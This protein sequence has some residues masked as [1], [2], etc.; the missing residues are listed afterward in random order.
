MAIP[1]LVRL[2]SPK[3]SV[4]FAVLILGRGVVAPYASHNEF[5]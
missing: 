1:F 4:S 3:H 5:G 2:T